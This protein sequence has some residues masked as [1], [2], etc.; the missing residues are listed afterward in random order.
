MRNPSI[1]QINQTFMG[2]K[3]IIVS[4]KKHYIDEK[5]LGDEDTNET[6]EEVETVAEQAAD[7]A[8]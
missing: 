2:K 8:A 7:D 6:L 4:G 5:K 3:F 1:F